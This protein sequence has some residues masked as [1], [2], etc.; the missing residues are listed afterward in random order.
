M[1]T[2]SK[3]NV[4]SN[5]YHVKYKKGSSTLEDVALDAGA[6]LREVAIHAGQQNE[7]FVHVVRVQASPPWSLLPA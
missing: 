6:K 2:R 1:C 3:I 7:G 5:K 4:C